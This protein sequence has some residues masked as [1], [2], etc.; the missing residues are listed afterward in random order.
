MG[1]KFK[2]SLILILG[3]FTS[4]VSAKAQTYRIS[5]L[6]CDPGEDLYMAF[7]HSAIRVLDSAKGTDYV[8]N[9][10]TFNFNTPN[11]YGKFAGGKLDYMLSVSSYAD[12]VATY[13]AEQRGI[14]EQVLNLSV[15][16]QQQMVEFLQVNYLPE[17]R[18]YRYDFFFDNCATRIRDALDLVL[19]DQLVWNDQEV[20]NRERTFRELIDEYVLRIPWADL[21]IDLALGAVIDRDANPEEEQFLPDYMEAA[22]ARAVIE[23]DGPSRPLVKETQVILEFPKPEEGLPAIN[24]YWIFWLV[25]IA[26]TGI[27]WIGFKQK[28]LWVGFDIG[29]F[30]FLGILGIIVML[31]WFA[32]EHSATKWNWNSLW[33]FPGHLFLA[34]GLATKKLKSWVRP[35]LLF[36]LIMAD[37]A[38]VFWILGWQS[39]HPSLIPLM[40]VIILRTNYLYYNIEK[41][42]TLARA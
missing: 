4:L 7:G 2:I 1:L 35:Y 15:D 14:R 31:L 39:F 30:A 25:A 8:F 17:R 40:L 34:Y 23:G 18:Y 21:G 20:N 27:T 10:G 6:T 28:R 5:L 22:F 36:A 3:I 13:H 12:F 37:A 16:Q 42:K 41:Y 38:V 9:Y 11:F 26:F 33:A 32:T 29:L 19:G 24:P